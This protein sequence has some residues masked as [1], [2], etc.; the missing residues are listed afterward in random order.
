MP[1][2]EAYNNVTTMPRYP[3][4]PT[5]PQMMSPAQ[6]IARATGIGARG[7]GAAMTAGTPQPVVFPGGV[8]PP[9]APP[10]AAPPAQP[11]ISVLPDLAEEAETAAFDPE[12]LDQ[13]SVLVKQAQINPHPGI[14]SDINKIVAK[15]TGVGGELISDVS[16]MG[17]KAIDAIRTPGVPEGPNRPALAGWDPKTQFGRDLRS[18]LSVIP[19]GPPPVPGQSPEWIRNARDAVA[20]YFGRDLTGMQPGFTLVPQPGNDPI[21]TVAAATGVTPAQRPGAAPA[22]NSP[23]GAP[24]VA[25]PTPLPIGPAAGQPAAAAAPALQPGFTMGPIGPDGQPVM[26]GTVPTAAA[27]PVLAPA[28]FTTPGGAPA[29]PAKDRFGL[30]ADARKNLA[31]IGAMTGV[32]ASQPGMTMAGALAQGVAGGLAAKE[33]EDE[34][35]MASALKNRELNIQEANYRAQA[36]ARLSEIEQRRDAA[37]QASADRQEATAARQDAARE[38]AEIRRLMIAADA[39]NKAATRQLNAIIA[40]GRIDDAAADHY[41][42]L[43]DPV[44]GG[45]KPADAEAQTA[46]AFPMSSMG[47]RA[48]INDLTAKAQAA[49]ANVKADPTIDDATKARRAA[50][51][52]NGLRQR[53]T[54]ISGEMNGQ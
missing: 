38:T 46:S 27:T 22:P 51:L 35:K 1:S 10:P 12:L 53:I 11:G 14:R 28:P 2:R 52:E 15:L 7:L 42:K 23:A 21:R 32:A 20:D 30:T 13:L 16:V 26:P 33:K 54:L 24:G 41:A 31:M 19:S 8:T 4:G 50:N 40:Q 6:I 9:A 18:A 5:P 45:L 37:A 39:G 43:I 49:I 34:K 29:A 44:T 48:R 36:Q 25:R 3:V 17:G 47:R